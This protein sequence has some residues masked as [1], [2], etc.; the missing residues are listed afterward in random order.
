[1]QPAWRVQLC[2]WCMNPAVAFRG[3]QQTASS[4][5]LT[6]GTLSPLDSMAYEV[7]QTRYPGAVGPPA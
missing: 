3:L 7:S 6:S 4:V 5:V 1:M 2:L